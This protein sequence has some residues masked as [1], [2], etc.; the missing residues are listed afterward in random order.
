[1]FIRRPHIFMNEEGGDG[2][3][4]GVDPGTQPQEP[5]VAEKLQAYMEQREAQ[6]DDQLANLQAQMSALN[7]QLSHKE[8]PE[9][10][11]PQEN[12]F[13]LNLEEL[14]E[15]EQKIVKAFMAREQQKDQTIQAL[16]QQIQV[17]QDQLQGVTRSQANSVQEQTLTH[18]GRAIESDPVLRGNPD[19]FR[20]SA[21]KDLYFYVKSFQA[22]NGGASPSGAQ[23]KAENARLVKAYS[24]RFKG[25]MRLP[26]P[27]P[28][29]D[30]FGLSSTLS[31]GMIP[32][33]EHSHK[34]MEDA[35]RGFEDEF[36]KLFR[37]GSSG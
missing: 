21:Q 1:M 14:H 28:N 17:I 2:G 36:M 26:E 16:T 10:A 9:A 19:F 18:L 23:L 37:P 34:S 5:G 4:P 29:T 24:E 25:K 22:E 35:H 13:G 6:K 33:R 3:D 27:K 31:G 20:E 15:S 7:A 30:M 11:P 32:T 8:E 12:T